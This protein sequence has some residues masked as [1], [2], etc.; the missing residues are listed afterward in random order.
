MEEDI[1]KDSNSVHG[2]KGIAERLPVGTFVCSDGT[3]VGILVGV[4]VGVGDLEGVFVGD[5]DFDFDFDFG[6]F[7]GEDIGA[8]E[9]SRVR[10]SVERDTLKEGDSI[11]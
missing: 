10:R 4:S 3:D 8:V 2:H 11:R 5:F 6:F 7:V 9:G 1:L